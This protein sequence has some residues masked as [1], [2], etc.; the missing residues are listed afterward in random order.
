M[1]TRRIMRRVGLM[2]VLLASLPLFGIGC[3]TINI[4]IDIPLGLGGTTG[5]FSFLSPT[6]MIGTIVPLL[7]QWQQALFPQTTP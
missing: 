2:A 4:F 1:I 7:I 3:G 5:L 6:N